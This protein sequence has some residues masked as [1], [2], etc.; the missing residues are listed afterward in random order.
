[1]VIFIVQKREL[2]IRKPNDL[3]KV[4]PLGKRVIAPAQLS[5]PTRHLKDGYP[6][7]L[8]LLGHGEGTL[9]LM[10]WRG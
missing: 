7:V 4:M 6:H 3:L 9:R 10:V 5:D 2:R 1:M 8:I